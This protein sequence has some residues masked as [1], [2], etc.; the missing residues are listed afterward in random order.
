MSS[1]ISMRPSK[2]IYYLEIARATAMRSTCLKNHCGAVIVSHDTIV[3]TGYNGAPRGRENCIDIGHC[4]R[5][6]HNIPSGE[7]YEACLDGGTRIIL[8]N[9]GTMSIYEM[10]QL[11]PKDYPEILA[12]NNQTKALVK[13]KPLWVKS[14]G[15]EYQRRGTSFGGNPVY[16]TIDHRF[17]IPTDMENCVD[18]LRAD[19]LKVGGA[20]SGIIRDDSTSEWRLTNHTISWVGAAMACDHNSAV[21]D[22]EIPEHHNFAIEVGYNRGVFV[23]NCRSVH[24]EMNAIIAADRDKMLNG[25]MYIYQWD[26]INN[27]VRQNPGCCQLC[28]RMIIN[29][30][31]EEVI[32]AD[33]MG[34]GATPTQYGYRVQKVRDWVEHE[35]DNPI[36]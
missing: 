8:A 29:A 5:V 1:V 35:S 6:S 4:Y 17:M 22:M 3:S 23:H 2:I 28:Q 20:A 26:P 32:F 9:G 24:G 7:R 36:G 27:C 21:Y 12:R 11:D 15:I 33:P 10:S 18:Y 30:G 14:T 25:S 16:S 19:C 13:V 34:I 31:I